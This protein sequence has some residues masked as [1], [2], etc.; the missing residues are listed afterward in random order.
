MHADGGRVLDVERPFDLVVGE[1]PL[2]G[3]VDRIEWNPGR[4]ELVIVD[5]KTGTGVAA[6]DVPEHAQLLAYQFAFLRGG[7]ATDADGAEGVE[8]AGAAPEVSAALIPEG[9]RLAGAA[10]LAVGTGSVKAAFWLQPALDPDDVDEFAERVQQA[11]R[12]MAGP[13]FTAAVAAHCTDPHAFGDCSTH[14]VKAVS[15]GSLG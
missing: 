9:A 3:A 14:I 15:H 1:T 13:V 8:A 6:N 11:S 5:L 4:G 12:G 2:R 7:M 10:I